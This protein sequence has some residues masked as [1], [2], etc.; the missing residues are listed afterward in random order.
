MIFTLLVCTAPPGTL[1]DIQQ[2]QYS[3][4]SSAGSARRLA[5]ATRLTRSDFRLYMVK[6]TITKAVI[7]RDRNLKGVFA[8][9]ERGYRLNGIIS[10]LSVAS[11]RRKLL[12]TST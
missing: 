12:K 7:L 2:G 4:P 10:L 11:I 9:N 1:A 8:K 6:F 5:C 3:W